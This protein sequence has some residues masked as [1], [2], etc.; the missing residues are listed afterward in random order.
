MDDLL[1]RQ[2]QAGAGGFYEGLKVET[3]SG[4]DGLQPKGLE[5]DVGSGLE[6]ERGL[7]RVAAQEAWLNEQASIPVE[8][9]LTS[10]GLSELRL[11]GA[12]ETSSLNNFSGE[13]R[14]LLVVDGSSEQWQSLSVSLPVNTDVLL[15][16]S[17]IDGFDQIKSS[18]SDASSQGVRY[19][20][21]AVVVTSES[22]KINFGDSSLNEGEMSW[23]VIPQLKYFLP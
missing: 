5:N 15:L 10:S 12:N 3:F 18:L 17:R 14:S 22:N 9:W 4:G 20:S 19:D 23:D 11:E 7:E 1:K 6:L 2:N 8:N 13:H 16:D 21:V